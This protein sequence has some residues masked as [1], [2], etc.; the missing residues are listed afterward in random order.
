MEVVAVWMVAHW[1]VQI[2]DLERMAGDL[3]LVV[4]SACPGINAIGFRNVVK[5][6]GDCRS[7]ETPLV[8]LAHC[9]RLELGGE[10]VAQ[11]V[12]EVV[13]VAGWRTE[14]RLLVE[15]QQ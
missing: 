11:V 2:W 12:G 10:L 3:W 4:G 5:S 8:C 13:E 15:I 7:H 9:L 14:P 6:W 1:W